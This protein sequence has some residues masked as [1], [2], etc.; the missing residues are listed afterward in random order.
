MRQEGRS[1]HD[2]KA[3]YNLLSPDCK[4]LNADVSNVYP[5]DTP[6]SQANL[7]YDDNIV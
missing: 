2:S 7:S 6:D 4:T 3:F 5:P 1:N